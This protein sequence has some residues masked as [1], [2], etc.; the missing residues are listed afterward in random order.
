MAEL[1]NTADISWYCGHLRIV[2]L[3]PDRTNEAAGINDPKGPVIKVTH[4]RLQRICNSQAL[5]RSA[6]ICKP[7]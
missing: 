7:G 3:G 4:S 6:T 1:V 2:Y 5:C